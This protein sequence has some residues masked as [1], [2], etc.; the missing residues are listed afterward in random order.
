LYRFLS[1]VFSRI[2]TTLLVIVAAVIFLIISFFS[3]LTIKPHATILLV[4]KL[5]IDKYEI[6]IEHIELNNII[7][8]PNIYAKNILI[9]SEN[10]D[11]EIDELDIE[12]NLFRLFNKSLYFEKLHLQGFEVTN[13]ILEKTSKSN[14]LNPFFMYGNDLNI[15][16]NT[17]NLISSEFYLKS[18]N[19][20][21][22]IKLIDGTVNNISYSQLNIFMNNKNNIHYSGVH[23]L[24]TDDLERLG[25]I[26]KSDF[27]SIDI[28]SNILSRGKINTS[29]KSKNRSFYK[30]NI[31]NSS[32]TFDSGYVVSNIES[33]L[34]SGLDNELY[35]VFSSSLPLQDVIQD[36]SGSVLYSKIQGLKLVSS[37]T[38]DM[39]KLMK[40][41]DYFNLSGKESF[42]TSL[43]ITPDQK[44]TLSLNTD[45][46]GTNIFSSINEI[47]KPSGKALS[48]IITIPNL[49][50][51]SYIISNKLFKA[52]I[53]Q[54]GGNGYFIFGDNQ[55]YEINKKDGFH[56][57]LNLDLFDFSSVKFNTASESESLVKT[58]TLKAK[59]FKM[60]NNS[61]LDQS[62][63]LNFEKDGLYGYF[64]GSSLNGELIVDKT[65][66]SKITINETTI[67]NLNFLSQ[68]NKVTSNINNSSIINMRIQGKDI[69]IGGED[70]EE[71]DFYILRNK[72]LIT[73]EDINI[74]SS[75]VNIYPLNSDETAFIS[76]SNNDD[77]YKIKGSF[78]IDGNSKFI[79]NS[80]KYNFE[81]LNADL[82]IQWNSIEDLKNIEGKI[83]FLTKN[84]MVENNISSSA[85]LN[86]LKILNLDAIIKN[87]DSKRSSSNGSLYL[88]RASGDIIFSAKRGLISN[89]ISIETDEAKMLWSGEILK[90]ENGYLD[91][92][93]LDMSM[94]IKVS[95]NLPWYA[96]LIGGIPAVAGTLV[97]QDLF[98]EN[99]DA[100]SSIPFKVSGTITEPILNRS[101]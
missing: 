54:Y 81:F 101:N 45:L 33:N 75:Y 66:F 7:S 31:Y 43:K 96:A 83:K 19:D 58:I 38:I 69:S 20:N 23:N 92:L 1:K 72:N 51:P 82:S 41:N 39:S 55:G 71:I 53:D 24:F 10:R 26:N 11:I 49:E 68:K 63:K 34:F 91:D 87:L 95:E 94:R 17:I 15:K 56:I 2:Y 28:K 52:Q 50:D 27:K 65:G 30:I 90:N 44:I 89:P 64:D 61:F 74:K 46:K 5:L 36:I 37:F 79:K 35:G 59:E 84:F 99:I 73:I 14:K 62:I 3:F 8:N 25:I 6:S 97:F 48:T 12:F 4:D 86:A 80:H 60:L 18:F 16:T 22:S 32:I 100:A 40:A 93:N 76:Y 78:Q 88:T 47:A 13:Y 57:Y 98:E 42:K 77:L 9:S 67:E 29:D 70:F 85:F 21:Q